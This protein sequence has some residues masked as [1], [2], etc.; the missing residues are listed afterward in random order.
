MAYR[1]LNKLKQNFNSLAELWVETV[2]ADF[3]VR[4]TPAGQNYHFR[5]S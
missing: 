4:D 5:I 2:N 1:D 3:I